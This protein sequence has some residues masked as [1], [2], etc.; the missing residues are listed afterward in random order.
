MKTQPKRVRVPKYQ[1]VFSRDSTKRR[2][3]GKPDRCFD[4][5]YRDLR[6][7][8]IWEKFGWASEGYTAVG[9]SDLRSERIRSIRHGEEVVRRKHREPTFGEVWEKYDQWL[10]TNKSQTKDDRSRYRKHLEPRFAN[11][12]LSQISPMDLEKM[13]VELKKQGLSPA[14]VKHCLVIVR[15]IINKAI[16]WDMWKG[17][18]P[19]K[20]VKIP[21]LNNRRERFLSSEE[22]QRL[23]E[24]LLKVSAQLHDITLLSLHTGMRAGEIFNLQW[25]HLDIE[26]GLIHVADSRS[27][28]ARKAYMTPTAKEMFRGRGP[29]QQEEYI[30]K[31]SKGGKIKEV[32]NAFTMVVK[33]LGFN[34]GI[35]DLRQK[36]C[37][38][39]LR[40]TFASW[41]ALRGE[42]ILTIK[43][44]LGHQTLA[45][46]ER[47][48]HLIPDHKR[49]AVEGI[50]EVFKNSVKTEEEPKE[51]P[52]RSPRS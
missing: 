13:K 50:E 27:G 23:L 4:I 17:E 26:N 1:G 34:D 48:S 39:T 2:H 44:L 36:V 12:L 25:I 3:N 32:S 18:N 52:R 28:R 37:F 29:G 40:H 46:T 31:S 16:A 47:Y 41:M 5:C 49:R 30:F 7:K 15:Q 33:K 11:R 42:S 8:L 19:I 35:K 45:M 24:S 10:E 38:H 22:A 20:K 51:E 21:R 9:A 14:S 6:G 43:E